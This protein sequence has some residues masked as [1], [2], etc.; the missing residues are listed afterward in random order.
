MSKN[1]FVFAIALT[2]SLISTA[3]ALTSAGWE[4]WGPAPS[5]AALW[6]PLT[7]TNGGA[8]CRG[9]PGDGKD[10]GSA[11]VVRIK[12]TG[13]NLR[14]WF[15]YMAPEGASVALETEQQEF[16][17]YTTI[18]LPSSNGIWK[19]YDANFGNQPA[20]IYFFQLQAGQGDVGCLRAADIQVNGKLQ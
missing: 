2:F 6:C 16:V 14:V 9:N 17:P 19:G 13:G 20:G 3:N 10:S 11:I 18:F 4:T 7:G 1:I 15:A 8:Q 12:H 5:G